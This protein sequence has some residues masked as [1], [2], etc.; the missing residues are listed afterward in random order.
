M[1]FFF[2]PTETVGEEI[3]F[4][5]PEIVRK[6]NK[7]YPGDVGIF[8]VYFFNIVSLEPGEALFID[9]NVPHSYLSGGKISFHTKLYKNNHTVGLYNYTLRNLFYCIQSNFFLF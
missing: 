4:Y 2:I 3:Q 6:L 8:A 9:A 5:L 1:V 7:E